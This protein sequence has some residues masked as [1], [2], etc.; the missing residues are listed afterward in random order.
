MYVPRSHQRICR[1]FHV[2]PATMGEG[3]W[4]TDGGYI[5]SSRLRASTGI[6][7]RTGPNKE[8]IV[9]SIFALEITMAM[10]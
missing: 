2:A 8:K 10:I 1:F 9:N 4:F 3:G 7:R 5:I 6:Q